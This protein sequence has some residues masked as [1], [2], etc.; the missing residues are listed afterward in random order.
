MGKRND[1]VAALGRDLREELMNPAS[2]R[3]P[4][5]D[6]SPGI[7]RIRGGSEGFVLASVLYVDVEPELACNPAG[8]AENVSAGVAAGVALDLSGVGA[9]TPER[10]ETV[11]RFIE[12]LQ[13]RG[14]SAVLHGVPADFVTA[15]AMDGAGTH[16]ARTENLTGAVAILR[17][18]EMMRR[19]CL[20]DRG[21]RLNQL[22]M[23][24]HALS[25]APLCAHARARLESAGVPDEIG[26]ELLREARARMVE[27]LDDTSDLDLDVSMSVTVHEGRA[28]LTLLDSGPARP[29]IADPSSEGGPIDRVHRF[30]I[31]DRHN[32]LVLE[33]D[34]AVGI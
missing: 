31:L 7:T 33:K 13:L 11:T 14:T 22:R 17:E 32:A 26:R 8:F 25:F 3:P 30:R 20:S 5:S 15:L 9:P 18:Y 34:L 19:R 16:V 1:G 29:G 23:P 28:T 2:V 24:L 6:P 21:Q 27:L 4:V 12:E 10:T